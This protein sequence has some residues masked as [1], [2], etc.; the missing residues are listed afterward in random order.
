MKFIIDV[1]DLAVSSRIA[2]SY[3]DPTSTRQI[4]TL[5]LDDDRIAVSAIS[6]ETASDKLIVIAENATDGTIMRFAYDE[7]KKALDSVASDR[8]EIRYAGDD[9]PVIFEQVKPTGDIDDSAFILTKT[10]PEID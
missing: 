1:N 10:S 6:T 4:L 7:F 8:V 2:M 5:K 9:V 3:V